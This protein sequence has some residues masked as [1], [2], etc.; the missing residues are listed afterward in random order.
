MLQSQMLA[1]E[2]PPD[3]HELHGIGR[4][5]AAPRRTTRVRALPFEGEHGRDQIYGL[6]V[7]VIPTN[8]SMQRTDLNDLVFLSQDEKYEAIVEDVKSCIEKGAPILVGTASI[9]TS[10]EMSRRFEDAKI[11]H[12]VLNAKFHEQEAQIIAQAG[13]P[14][15]VTIA[16]NMAGR[17]TDIVLG[18]NWEAEIKA[19]DAA[20]DEQVNAIR[21]SWEG[22]HEKVVEAGGLHIFGTERHE[23]RRID[24]QLRG[25]AGRQ[26]DPGTSRF[27]LSLEDNL[28]RIFASERVKNFMQALGMER[29]EAIEHTTAQTKVARATWPL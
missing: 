15:T 2:V 19:L 17:G 9:E 5:P 3:F 7:V 10:E 16:T 6:P 1:P 22:R 23:S 28:M 14:G 18:G 12:Q 27:Y 20:N 11:E 29:G 8:V 21:S 25:R 4:A 24:N 26:G 13:M